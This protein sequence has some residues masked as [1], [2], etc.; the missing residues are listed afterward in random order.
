MLFD[1][2]RYDIENLLSTS[3]TE[4][5]VQIDNEPFDEDTEEYIYPIVLD[6]SSD[7]IS[8][9][10]N[11]AHRR[12]GVLIIQIFVPKN[13]GTLRVKVLADM[14][15]VLFKELKLNSIQFES[16]TLVRVGQNH[17]YHQ[18]NFQVPYYV[19]IC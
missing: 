18:E 2:S 9:G 19:D 12:V 13:T 7:Q 4:T 16:P 3:W 17:R 10:P 11:A 15:S 14:L 6:G 8:L 5:P 1:Q